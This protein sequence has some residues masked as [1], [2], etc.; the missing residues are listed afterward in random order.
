LHERADLFWLRFH[1]ITPD[2]EEIRR[3]LSR[4]QFSEA[5]R[6]HRGHLWLPLDTDAHLAGPEL[7][8]Q[9]ADQ[10]EAIVTALSRGTG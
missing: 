4:S 2:F 6:E 10:V 3:L 1:R 5:L 9:I 7:V 8:G